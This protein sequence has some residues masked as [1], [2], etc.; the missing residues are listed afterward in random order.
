M[1]LTSIIAEIPTLVCPQKDLLL[2][3]FSHPTCKNFLL[4]TLVIDFKLFTVKP[5]YLMV[6]TLGLAVFASLIAPF[7]GFFASG[8]KR[9]IN[10]K[11][12]GDTI[13]GH[14]GIT[15]RMDCQLMMGGFAYFFIHNILIEKGYLYSLFLQDFSPIQRLSLFK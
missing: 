7:G 12:F 1:V 6:Y 14:G 11:D 15:D 9:T 8:L 4:D 5:T 3:P 2:T 13:P 10:I